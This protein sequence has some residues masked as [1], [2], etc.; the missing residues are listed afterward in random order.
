MIAQI[1]EEKQRHISLCKGQLPLDELINKAR[2]AINQRHSFKSAISNQSDVNLIAE[3]KKASPSRGVIRENFNPSEIAKAYQVAGASAISI[4]TEE[5]YFLGSL[6]YINIV[7]QVCSLPVLRKDFIV[8][9]Y[10]IY[11]SCYYGA[12]AVLLIADIL[13]NDQIVKFKNIATSLNMDSLIEI[14]SEEDLEKV[15]SVDADIIGINN[16][17][18]HT[19]K[20]NLKTS[21]NLIGSIPKGKIIVIESGIKSNSDLMFFK[22]L[23]ANAV[24]I[25]E[26]FME[27]KDIGAKVKEVLGR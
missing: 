10:Q 17:D 4:L 15:I 18:L 6:D 14:H 26:A 22:S 23:G 16:R 20:L 21:E 25:G 3:I 8:D 5:K 24:L 1:I 2:E 9:E 11:E 27:N 13:S 7:K 12:D 19:F